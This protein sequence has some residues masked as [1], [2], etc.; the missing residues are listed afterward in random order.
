MKCCFEIYL[1]DL[2]NAEVDLIEKFI[3][4]YHSNC[5]I[6]VGEEAINDLH[7]NKEDQDN[8]KFTSIMQ[9]MLKHTNT[10]ELNYSFFTKMMIN[11]GRFEPSILAT[12]LINVIIDISVRP[13]VSQKLINE[14]KELKR[15]Y[16]KSISP[17]ILDKMVYLD[18]VIKESLELS[19]PVS[20]M[21]KEF[22]TDY[23]LSNGYTIPKSSSIS[24][25]LFSK[26][27]YNNRTRPNK[28]SFKPDRHDTKN[29]LIWG[30]SKN[31]CPYVEYCSA[32]MKLFVCILIRNYYI[33]SNI[34]GIEPVHPGYKHFTSVLPNSSTVFL[35]KHDIDKY[36]SNE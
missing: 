9:M 13:E 28:I 12:R 16:G 36:R 32:K 26:Y 29:T 14:Q 20:C 33:F 35:K 4:A 30:Q 21:N 34:D 7:L 17:F 22:K 31:I 10:N 23:C 5:G 27:R 19:A 24:H 15:I 6:H 18:A 25:N 11:F 3:N 8:G 2:I 1:S